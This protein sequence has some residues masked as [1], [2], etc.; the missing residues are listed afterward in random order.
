MMYV[1]DPARPHLGGNAAGGDPRTFYPALWA[2]L[3]RT[4]KVRSVLDVGCGEGHALA[5]FASLGCQ[6]VGI[7]GLPQ[8][9]FAG[10]DFICHDMTRGPARVDHIDLVWSCE[11]AEHIAPEFVEHYLATLCQGR[12]VAMTHAVPGQGGWHHVNE[13]PAEYWIERVEA[14]G[15]RLDR[16]HTPYA[17][18]LAKDYFA[19]TGLIF[20]KGSA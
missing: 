19:A 12:V 18:L 16:D 3:V 13:Q 17:R 5:H 20:T 9:K 4:Y 2:W 6:T 10:A 14:R 11:V 8:C 1:T 15:Y 7:D